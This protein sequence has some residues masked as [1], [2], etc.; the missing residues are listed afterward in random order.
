MPP[1]ATRDLLEWQPGRQARELWQD[2]LKQEV[3]I[4]TLVPDHSR[5]AV[6]DDRPFNEYFLL[7][8]S[9]KRFGAFLERTLSPA[10]P[11]PPSRSETLRRD[12]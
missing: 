12:L 10:R 4:H 6:P 8:R 11:M 1:S 3:D 5:L 9:L 2:M 7:R